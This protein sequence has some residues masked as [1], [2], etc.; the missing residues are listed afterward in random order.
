QTGAKRKR[1][2]PKASHAAGP[3]IAPHTSAAWWD[4]DW[5]TPEPL[6][7]Q[8]QRS[9]VMG[10]KSHKFQAAA[11]QDL[12]DIGVLLQRTPKPREQEQT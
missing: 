6:Q 12:Q 7:T 1:R 8:A 4:L 10:K 2:P 5:L 3:K 11:S 9:E